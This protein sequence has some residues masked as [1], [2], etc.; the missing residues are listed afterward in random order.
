MRPVL[1][2]LSI[3]CGQ[4][5]CVFA[6]ILLH[7]IPTKEPSGIYSFRSALYLI[8]GA[9]VTALRSS[10]ASVIVGGDHWLVQSF[11][12]MSQLAL[13]MALPPWFLSPAFAALCLWLVGISILY[14]IDLD[15][16]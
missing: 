2:L 16:S 6:I 5:G 9:A 12:S 13:T 3:L 11:R 14:Y 15:R 4:L 7:P 10:S 8:V 1:L